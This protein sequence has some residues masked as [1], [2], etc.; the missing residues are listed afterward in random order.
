MAG[1]RGLLA[2]RAGRQDDA[3]RELDVAIAMSDE[4]DPIDACRSLL[5]RGVLHMERREVAAARADF[6]DCARRSR[7]AGFVRLVFKAEHNLG[8]LASSRDACRR[9]WRVMEAAAAILPGRPADRSAG[10]RARAAGGGARRC[11][12][13]HAGRGGGA[14]R[15]AAPAADVAECELGRAECAMLRGDLAGAR[16]SRCRPSG[17]S[18]VGAT[19]RG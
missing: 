7:Q 3:L 12:G 13:Q 10:P 8:Y 15:R 17:G 2:L 14:V 5:N 6:A 9:R 11:R 1:L 16:A 18:V 4:A 19:T